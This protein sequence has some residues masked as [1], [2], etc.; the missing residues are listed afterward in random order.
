MVGE[1][2]A[3]VGRE[4]GFEVMSSGERFTS[5]L[6]IEV[7]RLPPEA[8]GLAFRGELPADDVPSR[9]GESLGDNNAL[10]F[11]SKDIRLKWLH[12]ATR[13]SQTNKA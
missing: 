6:K 9:A 2:C 8:V 11:M 3:E 4:D 13:T 7:A 10:M 1:S 5:W 12:S